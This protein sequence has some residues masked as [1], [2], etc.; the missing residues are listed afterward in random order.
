MTEIKKRIRKNKSSKEVFKYV[1]DIPS[2]EIY[3][4]RL[5]EEHKK[6]LARQLANH[7]KRLKEIASKQLSEFLEE[8]KQE[9]KIAIE[10]EIQ[11]E[12]EQEK[13]KTLEEV[14]QIHKS[15]RIKMT[16]ILLEQGETIP[17]IAETII[18]SIEET[19]ELIE[20]IEENKL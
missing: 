17:K 19:T 20:F 16:K 3:I 13:P 4:V 10:Q 15:L 7:K 9:N 11:V 1:S 8:I 2:Y 14:K 5:Q 12:I 18:L 6:N